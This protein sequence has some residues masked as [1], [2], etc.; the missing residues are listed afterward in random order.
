MEWP[1][2][3][4]WSFLLSWLQAV[5]ISLITIKGGI[6]EKIW[7]GWCL[8]HLLYVVTN[9]SFPRR[10]AG[11]WWGSHH[12]C[13]VLAAARDLLV[14]ERMCF[15]ESG[16]LIQ[17]KEDFVKRRQAGK[18][19]SKQDWICRG[20]EQTS[21]LSLEPDKKETFPAQ[22]GLSRVFR[23]KAVGLSM[24]LEAQIES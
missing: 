10:M 9:W 16:C 13:P 5:I 3:L 17:R 7:N 8:F 12:L 14:R 19:T 6:F 21:K 18:K 22:R 23:W 20:G 15:P 1:L 24:S 2:T 4:I 11:H